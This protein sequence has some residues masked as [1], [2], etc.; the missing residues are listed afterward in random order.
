MITCIF[1]AV[2]NGDPH[3][4][5]FF[6]KAVLVTCHECALM[7][8]SEW[9]P[10]R[11][12]WLRTSFGMLLAPTT[13]CH[14]S[15]GSGLLCHFQGSGRNHLR[16]GGKHFPSHVDT[17]FCYPIQIRCLQ[18]KTLPSVTIESLSCSVQS[19]TWRFNR[20]W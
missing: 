6:T 2:C 19:L 20:I 7:M 12:W 3:C 16:E 15:L 18:L 10:L 11:C 17:P 4:I 14:L 5:F 9:R 8:F 13:S 1:G